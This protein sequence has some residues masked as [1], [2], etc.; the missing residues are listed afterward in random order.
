MRKL[1][2]NRPRS[3]QIQAP[4]LE[5]KVVDFVGLRGEV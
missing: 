4:Q 2:E 3:L 5:K 1:D